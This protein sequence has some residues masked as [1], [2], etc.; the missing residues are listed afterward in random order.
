M[1]RATL[2]AMKVS[3]PSR[4]ARRMLEIKEIEHRV[5]NLPPGLHPA[6]LRLA[7]FRGGTVPALKL[8]GRR[9]QGSTA[10][11]RFL[12]TLQPDPP[13]FPA[14]GTARRRVEEAEAWGEQTLQDAPRKLFRWGLVKDAELRRWLVEQAG[15]PAPAL[16]ART[17]GPNARWFA[18]RSKATDE[19]VRA[20]LQ[21]LPAMLDRVD[22][23]IAAGTIGNGPPNAADLQIGSSVR[24][25]MQYEELKALLPFGRPASDHALHLFPDF[26][27]P[28]PAF[29]PPDWVPRA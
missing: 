21:R 27:G 5:V 29:L 11:S 3:H 18:R 20:E 12:D 9:V 28:L 13:L 17:G 22:E 19:N 24:S 16:A 23:L 1:A 6:A 15:L 4:A 2:Y 7:R 10:I 25:L 8:D 26:P 14:G